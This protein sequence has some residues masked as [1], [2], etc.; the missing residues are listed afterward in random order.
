MK[1]EKQ[2][3]TIVRRIIAMIMAVFMCISLIIPGGEGVPRVY[4]QT[5]N[6]GSAGSGNL[7]TFLAL[8]M[9]D[10]TTGE[11][12]VENG[13]PTGKKVNDGDDVKIMFEFA[14]GMLDS[15]EKDDNGN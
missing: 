11:I 3:R 2:K 5:E 15:I 13:T 6:V 9:K 12:I 14:I 8:T 7:V 1:T 10:V 4:A